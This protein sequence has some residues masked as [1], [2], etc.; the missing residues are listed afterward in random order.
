MDPEIQQFVTTALNTSLNTYYRKSALNKL[1]RLKKS[2]ELSSAILKLLQDVEDE[3]LQKEVMDLAVKFAISSAVDY[4]IPI[5]AGNGKNARYALSILSKLGG[6]Y[7]YSYLK[8][9]ADKP[10]FDLTKNAAS[11]A[12]HDLLAREPELE[13]QSLPPATV[14]K[15]VV[16]GVPE[17]SAPS[18]LQPSAVDQSAKREV[19]DLK[20]SL[21]EKDL[22]INSLMATL[23]KKEKELA[24]LKEV[25]KQSNF[26]KIEDENHQLRTELSKVTAAFKT[27]ISEMNLEMS[28]LNDRLALSR[29]SKNKDKQSGGKG[30]LIFLFI[31]FLIFIF[32]IL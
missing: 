23:E 17:V 18:K 12:L 20:R 25:Q 7:S 2:A 29:G 16:V 21:R 30:C 14:D 26:L 22:K 13:S 24:E 3:S 5:G 8:S 32:A 28:D 27:K 19:D 1:G 11:R 9:L 10:G 6:V 31:V 4:I 15:K